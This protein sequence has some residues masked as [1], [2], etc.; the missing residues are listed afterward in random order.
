MQARINRA[1]T[2]AGKI[3]SSAGQYIRGELT[4]QPLGNRSICLEKLETE[5]GNKVTMLDNLV[6]NLKSLKADCQNWATSNTKA[7]YENYNKYV[8]FER[9]HDPSY[10]VGEAILRIDKTIEQIEDFKTAVPVSDGKVIKVKSRP[11]NYILHFADCNPLLVKLTKTDKPSVFVYDD[12]ATAYDYNV[13]EIDFDYMEKLAKELAESAEAFV[14]DF[15]KNVKLQNVNNKPIFTK[16]DYA[17][18]LANAVSNSNSKR[19][20]WDVYTIKNASALKGFD[21]VHDAANKA[22]NEGFDTFTVGDYLH[23]IA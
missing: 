21:D 14:P 11:D 15:V 9:Y 22:L 7:D 17:N 18:N 2:F 13:Y 8:D 16:V 19:R 1:A 20:R 5:V 10:S 6:T 3:E 23:L 4:Y 12:G